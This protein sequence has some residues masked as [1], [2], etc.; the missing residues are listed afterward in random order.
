MEMFHITAMAYLINVLRAIDPPNDCMF[1]KSFLKPYP[2]IWALARRL[3]EQAISPCPT[4][5]E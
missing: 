1:S 3:L 2:H 4:F 5:S